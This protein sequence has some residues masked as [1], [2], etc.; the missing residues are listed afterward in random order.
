M[1]ECLIVIPYYKNNLS[2]LEK[3]SLSK[4]LEIF[5]FRPVT[6][7]GPEDLHVSQKYSEIP[8][9][10]FDKKYFTSLQ[11]Y[12]QLLLSEEFYKRFISYKYI[13]IYQLDALAFTD[14][15][16]YWCN[17]EYDYYGA[18][19]NVKTWR[20]KYFNL[21]GLLNKKVGNG[22]FSLRNTKV[23]LDM[24]KK[25]K[26]LTKYIKF[27]EDIFWSNYGF[28]FKREFKVAPYHLAV[29]FAFESD[30]QQ[31][32]ASNDFRLPFGCHAYAK[33]DFSFWK[34]VVND[35]PEV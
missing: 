12:N 4:G 35:F 6:F 16:D 25:A 13:L 17:L 11:G 26:W 24:A 14:E 33:N 34:Q 31:L 9:E 28:F 7:I 23:F 30:P 10:R 3:Y 18:P 2:G 27:G 22:G 15:L 21:F 19:W 5:S 29:R 20:Y 1:N 8:V 32:F